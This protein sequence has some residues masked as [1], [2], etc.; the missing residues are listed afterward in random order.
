MRN[1]TFLIFVAIT[2]ICWGTYGPTL[3]HGQ[4][5]MGADG[6]LSLLRP[7]I[8]VGIAYFLVAVIYPICVLMF[9]GEQGKWSV[10]GF[11]WS[12][13]AGALG[14]VGALGITLAFKF[15]GKPIFVMPLVFGCA[16]IMNTL[17]TMTMAKT[18]RQANFLFFVGIGM[19]A[20]GA[21]GV[22]LNKPSAVKIAPAMRTSEIENSS[23]RPASQMELKGRLVLHAMTEPV[24]LQSEANERERSDAINSLRE[25]P[26]QQ[27]IE[28]T[29]PQVSAGPQA[30]TEV[31]SETPVATPSVMTGSD[32]EP[33]QFSRAVTGATNWFMVILGIAITAISWGAYGP[34]LHKGQGKMAGSRLRPFLCVGLAYFAI[35]VVIPF[36]ALTY[37]PE[38]GS[39]L[40][41]QGWIAGGTWWSLGAGIL[42]AI[43]ALGIIYAFNFGGKPIFVMPLVFGF[44][45]VINTLVE[46]IS[47]G[48]VGEI[49]PF[50][51]PSLGLVIL[52]AVMVL[53]FAPKTA[54]PAKSAASAT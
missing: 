52:G 23:F 31:P 7:I 9:K 51:Y 32:S 38:P 2:F 26:A 43:G 25:T 13:I 28:P 40:N 49:K 14:A 45:P 12:F 18:F 50:F 8:C 24:F 48:L 22:L 41:S 20:L 30:V 15:D 3:H 27:E 5:G 37:F 36:W 44:A 29:E 34:V 42:G 4:T 19:V 53:V 47:K 11:W 21:A 33:G 39:W 16:P 10:S 17:V 46:T 1:L 35:A 6:K 54:P